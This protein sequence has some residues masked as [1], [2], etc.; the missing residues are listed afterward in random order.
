MKLNQAMVCDISP[1]V[2]T[3]QAEKKLKRYKG[4]I[5]LMLL[6]LPAILLIFGF[7]AIGGSTLTRL[8][9][10]NPWDYIIRQAA[11]LLLGTVLGIVL[12][13]K[14]DQF[15]KYSLP[16]VWATIMVTIFIILEPL[17]WS[18]FVY[19]EHFADRLYLFVFG[20]RIRPVYWILLFFLPRFAVLFQRLAKDRNTTAL[21]FEI[22]LLFSILSI[23]YVGPLY[24]VPAFFLLS[25]TF[26]FVI[27]FN[28]RHFNN[29]KICIFPLAMFW[30]FALYRVFSDSYHWQRLIDSYDYQK[31]P[32]VAGY[33]TRVVLNEF[34]MGGWFGNGL[35]AY[36]N[37]PAESQYGLEVMLPS[38]TLGLTAR[39]FGFAGVTGAVLMYVVWFL[40]G[41]YFIRQMKDVSKRFFAM[42][43]LVLLF[44][45]G[46]LG[47]AR[48]LNL[49]PF[50]P[51]MSLP[52]LGFNPAFLAFS[53]IAAAMIFAL[54]MEDTNRKFD[55]AGNTI[56]VSAKP[57]Q[58]QFS[59]QHSIKNK[60]MILAGLFCL[61]FVMTVAVSHIH[62]ISSL[63]QDKLTNRGRILDSNGIPLAVSI[64]KQSAWIDR[65][66]ADRVKEAYPFKFTKFIALLDVCF[67]DIKTKLDRKKPYDFGTFAW[68][69]RWLTDEEKVQLDAIIS[70][71]VY[72]KWSRKMIHVI[73]ESVRIYPGGKD[74]SP[75]IGN[76]LSNKLGGS[77][78]EYLY[79]KNLE[80]GSDL[81]LSIDLK[82]QKSCSE[83]MEKRL[84]EMG[85]QTAHAII[86]R[87]EDA[88]AL[89]LFSSFNNNPYQMNIPLKRFTP[90]TD[91]F[92]LGNFFFPFLLAELTE[93]NIYFYKDQR[94]NFLSNP[95]AALTKLSHHLG[96]EGMLNAVSRFGFTAKS[97]IGLPGESITLIYKHQTEED[98][99]FELGN[100]YGI[101]PNFV[102]T[103][104]SF[105]AIINGGLLYSPKIV[106]KIEKS[107]QNSA[108][109]ER[110]L[111]VQIISK[112]T[113]LRMRDFFSSLVRDAKGEDIL[114]DYGGFWTSYCENTIHKPVTICHTMGAFFTPADKPE[115]LV[116]F[117][118]SKTLSIEDVS[119][120][121]NSYSHEMN[122]KL[123]LDIGVNL[124]NAV[125]KARF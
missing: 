49:V 41:L 19:T 31:A 35:L 51:T 24:D 115:F 75:I 40:A 125:N 65:I 117:D 87:V 57:S 112:E 83:I 80:Q 114:S 16:I 5:T 22:V 3:T 63:D 111:P 29:F 12:V 11:G 28:F 15:L 93:Q 69:K 62:L 20:V 70:D 102:R 47:I 45:N 58:Q 27:G 118:I 32:Y 66:N 36:Q 86:L 82:L 94:D 37:I 30:S 95:N 122:K 21:N 53:C 1:V 7:I 106:Q 123:A 56:T 4:K 73:T 9:A 68:L 39:Q 113:S 46:G 25:I 101:A 17:R 96:S 38:F 42:F 74:F 59:I 23:F 109:P 10:G 78:I 76:V 79:N 44:A 110:T 90:V 64:D 100:G 8:F 67:E 88:T 104:V 92:Q 71:P 6:G 91:V 99:L 60:H 43:L 13:K 121:T 97:M 2:E 124:I 50:V 107:G 98:A 108:F 33:F 18:P 89:S 14:K 48:T 81:T 85:G 52:F 116:V 103:A 34:R 84:R 54:V 120:H 119:I 77:G 26:V 55:M 105:N 72:S 61:G